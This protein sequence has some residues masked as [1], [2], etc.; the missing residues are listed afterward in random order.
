MKKLWL[1]L[2]AARASLAMAPEKTSEITRW[3]SGFRESAAG[4][5]MTEPS[6]RSRDAVHWEADAP[7]LT[8]A[9]AV[10]RPAP[11]SSP[12]RAAV[13]PAGIWLLEVITGR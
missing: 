11:E 9:R 5:A 4:P 1:Q 13:W 6:A 8:S 3:E 10:V 12:W 2:T 7:R